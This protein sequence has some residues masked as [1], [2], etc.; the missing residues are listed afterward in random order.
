MTAGHYVIAWLERA[1]R[2]P[3]KA[4]YWFE[5]GRSKNY[6]PWR[7]WSE[8]DWNDG[9]AV[10]FITAGGMFLQSLLFGYGGVRFTDNG[11][12]FDAVLPPNVTAMKMRGLNFVQD[13]FD[14]T[15]DAAGTRFS[16]RRDAGA[17]A[18]QVR[19]AW[20]QVDQNGTWTGVHWLT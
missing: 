14:V 15:V 8:H 7:I 20:E 1:H 5:R 13:E 4:S 10:N 2:N 6:A 9:G 19:T 16:R 17:S 3:K 18:G 12:R 11:T